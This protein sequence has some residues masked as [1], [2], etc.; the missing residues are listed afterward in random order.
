M[1]CI[2]CRIKVSRSADAAAE[3]TTWE[4]ELGRLKET[5]TGRVAH[6]ACVKGEHYDRNQLTIAEAIEEE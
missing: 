3:F 5:P 2:V 4:T 1:K 6:L